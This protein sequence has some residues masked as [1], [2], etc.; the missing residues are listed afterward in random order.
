MHTTQRRHGAGPR[1]P[2]LIHSL[3]V[4][5]FPFGLHDAVTPMARIKQLARR[6]MFRS[7]GRMTR[8]LARIAMTMLWPCGA[9]LEAMKAARQVS[10]AGA[11]AGS[12]GRLRRWLSIYVLAL[13]DNVPPLEYRLYGFSDPAKRALA[14]DYLYWMEAPALAALN[15]RRGADGVDVQDKARF[16]EICNA[17]ALPCVPTLAAYAHG[18]QIS[19]AATFTPGQPDLWVKD[20]LGSQSSG[21]ERWRRAG[22]V[23]MGAGDRSVAPA[24]L[25]AEWRRRSCIVQPRLGNHPALMQFTNGA[26]AVLRIVTGLHP[27]GTAELV[28]AML[29]LPQGS[30]LT[31]S[32][33]ICCGLDRETGRIGRAISLSG[34]EVAVHPDTGRKLPGTIVPGWAESL[35]LARRAHATA[36]SRFVFLGW[37]IVPAEGGPLL[38]ETNAG[39]GALHHQMLDGP[40]GRT[41]FAAIA[42]QYL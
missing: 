23:Y 19:P 8:S 32:G 30:R 25:V 15:A 33:G 40:L 16:A 9:F 28:A 42:A 35:A 21:A 2:G 20:L 5:G 13:R 24:D 6:T 4:R 17:H 3:A 37:D 10:V 11:P 26:L 41:P 39:W 1:T 36:F 31:S 22:Q 38:L 7:R 12:G 29:L 34:E 14:A 27:T 18:R